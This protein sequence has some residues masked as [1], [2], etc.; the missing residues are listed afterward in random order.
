LSAIEVNVHIVMLEGIPESPDYEWTVRITIF[1]DSQAGQS[2]SDD[3]PFEADQED[4]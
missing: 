3:A 2:L 4:L 1:R